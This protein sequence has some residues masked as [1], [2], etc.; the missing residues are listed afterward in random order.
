VS[1]IGASAPGKLV[2]LGEYAVLFGH[3]AVVMAVDRRA[4]IEMSAAEGDHWSVVAPG[5]EERRVEFD[6]D[7]A[8]GFRWREPRSAAAAR[9]VLVERVFGSLVTARFVDP[10]DLPP[11]RLVVDTREFYLPTA[12]GEEKLGVGSSAALTVA[13][14]ETLRRWGA[15]S[16]GSWV[17]ID[18][19]SL[20]EIHRSFQGGSGSGID[21]AAS[22]NGGV[23]EYR[24]TENARFPSAQP[25]ALPGELQLVFVWAGRSASTSDFLARLETEI[26]SDGGAI[27]AALTELGRV[28]TTGI[29][30]I[31]AGEVGGLL[32]AVDA[33]ADV[34]ERLGHAAGIPIFSDEHVALHRLALDCGLSYKPSGAGGGDV[35]IGFSID[36][37]AVAAF[38]ERAAAAGFLPLDLEI[39]PVGVD[40]EFSILNSRF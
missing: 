11:A 18:L 34:M 10:E 14:T 28:S 4:R 15:D 3:P 13:L 19:R 27:A 40:S 5:F 22:R 33:F 1:S 32:A 12:A 37:E 36:P 26:R 16:S 24:L 2:L 30:H 25:I 31:R 35:G 39:D 9:F 23:V 7:G 38:A 17:P 8:G 6:L 20:L 21:L 29:G